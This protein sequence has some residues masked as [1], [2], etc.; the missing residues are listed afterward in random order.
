MR[1][2]AASCVVWLGVAVVLQS[3]GNIDA[4]DVVSGAAADR[5]VFTAAQAE[6]GARAF[7]G[8]CAGCHGEE[9]EGKAVV[10]A[11]KGQRFDQAWRGRPVGA[12]AFNLENLAAALPRASTGRR[13]PTFLPSS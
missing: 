8:H 10:P 9:L 7:A 3:C 6:R 1:C 11:L 13:T 12:L 2:N 4:D 5:P